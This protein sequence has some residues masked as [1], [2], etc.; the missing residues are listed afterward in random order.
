MNNAGRITL[1]DFNIEDEALGTET[2][3]SGPKY[4]HTD[5]CDRIES[6]KSNS[7]IHGHPICDHGAKRRQWT[8]ESLSNKWC[9]EAFKATWNTTRVDSDVP[10]G[11]RTT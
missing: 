6:P 7:N 11:T 2:A 10:P 9:W 5:P 3:Q 1:S 8:K 4:R